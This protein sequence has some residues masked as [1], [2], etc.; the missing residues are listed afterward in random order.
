MILRYST[1]DHH[2]GRSATKEIAM[3]FEMV[4]RS[5][6]VQVD[7]GDDLVAESLA[8]T[9]K[10]EVGEFYNAIKCPL[11]H[12][13]DGGTVEQGVFEVD[14]WLDHHRK[15]GDVE[16]AMQGTTIVS[17]RSSGAIVAVCLINAC[18]P[19]EDDRKFLH[20]GASVQ[21]IVVA[22]ESRRQGIATKMVQ[23]AMTIVANNRPRFDVWVEED[24]EDERGLF[25]SLDF[26]FTGVED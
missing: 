4:R 5:S 18:E 1:A 13:P 24:D 2:S 19:F 8:E 9:K 23:R 14:R 7:W 26:V 3:S 12:L 10:Q 20:A 25:E 6:K 11:Y 22:P 15:H 17:S 16:L 21:H